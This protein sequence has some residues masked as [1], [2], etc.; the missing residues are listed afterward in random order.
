MSINLNQTIS[1][2]WLADSWD[3]QRHLFSHKRDLVCHVNPHRLN[4]STS[5][6]SGPPRRSPTQLHN[7]TYQSLVTDTVLS[8]GHTGRFPV[9]S[10]HC[11]LTLSP[12]WGHLLLDSRD[13]FKV[14]HSHDAGSVDGVDQLGKQ[15]RGHRAEACTGFG[16]QYR[17]S[18]LWVCGL[19]CSNMGGL[20]V[21]P[22]ICF[23]SALSQAHNTAVA[24]LKLN[25]KTKT[26]N[27]QQKQPNLHSF[28]ALSGLV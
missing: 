20:W 14:S 22:P 28:L 10:C 8:L 13:S 25:N 9:S 12:Q 16:L 24:F 6:G 26:A 18:D 27:H 5:Q 17:L 19:Q 23:I 2:C 3:T 15:W 11:V 21:Y 4:S 7:T 1:H